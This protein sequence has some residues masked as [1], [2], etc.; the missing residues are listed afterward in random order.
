MM[1]VSPPD[2]AFSNERVPRQAEGVKTENLDGEVLVFSPRLNKTIY[3]S[4]TAALVWALCDGQRSART[5]SE[6]LAA[7]FPNSAER[8]ATDVQEALRNLASHG[9]LEWAETT[10]PPS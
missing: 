10:T 9:A 4:D 1:Q 8:V 6:M 2:E 5:I 3:L 7:A